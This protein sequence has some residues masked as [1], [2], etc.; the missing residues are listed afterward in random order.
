LSG[1]AAR[2]PIALRFGTLH[3]GFG[4]P[5]HN[6][7]LLI[8]GGTITAVGDS[9]LRVPPDAMTI[10]AA[11]V[12][13]GLI[14]AH[15]HLEMSG[16]AQTQ[17]V[18]VLTTPVQR[19]LVAAE[20]ARKTLASGVTAVRDLG[21][22]H[23][24][25]IGVRDAV[26]SGGLAGP[27]VVAAG[28]AICMTGGHG[29]FIGR[30][31]DGAQ[32]V[33]KAVREQ[34]RDGAD[35]I[36]FIAT[37]GV[38]T[39]GAVPGTAQLSEDEL[40]AGV[41]EAHAHGMTCAAHAIGTSGIANALRAGVDSIEHGHLVD[42][43]G[44]A[45]FVARKAYLVPTLAAIRCIIEGGEESGMPDFV[46]RKAREI[47]EHADENLR[48]AR[49][50]GVL[51]AGGSDAGTPFNYH[52]A[53]AYELELMQSMLGMSA[54][55]ALHAATVNAAALLGLRRGTLGAGDVADLAVLS[56]DI[57]SDARAFREPRIVIKNG[58]L[59]LDRR[60]HEG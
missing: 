40:R 22:S 36:K 26:A 33:R 56:H 47:A 19:A 29:W 2:A 52:D 46:L 43:E 57:E 23:S 49:A 14:N 1:L 45:L 16:E 37:G 31:A 51:F 6:G 21:S 34:R 48:R 60:A 28:H 9:A 5:K 7:V 32:D 11:C 55:E 15:V 8:D 27:S 50:A 38:L 10:E 24:I 4:E 30:E 17:S 39:K 12:I 35:C 20:N 58:A 42:D 13:P 25:A 3:D 18:F 53:Y 41:E 54:R 44:I 59:A